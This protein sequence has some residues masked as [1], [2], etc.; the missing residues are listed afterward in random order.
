M[1][2]TTEPSSVMRAAYEAVYAGRPLIVTDWPVGRAVFPF[3]V[4]VP[5]NASGIAAGVGDA[6]ARQAEL[7][8]VAVTAR[9]MQLDRWE[10]QLDELRAMLAL[11][12][13]GRAQAPVP[14]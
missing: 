10:A 11:E 12:P 4:H 6:V 8:Q 5:N 9:A 13:T 14:R 3:A 7:Q 2:L 1:T